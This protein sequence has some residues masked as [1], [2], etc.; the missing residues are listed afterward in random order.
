M[1]GA[2]A[3]PIGVVPP[4][5][6]APPGGLPTPGAPPCGMPGAPAVPIGDAP[7]TPGAPPG[8]LPTPGAP[9]CGMPGEP[10]APVGPAPPVLDPVPPGFLMAGLTAPDPKPG[11]APAPPGP[12]PV[13]PGPVAPAPLPAAAPPPWP[14]TVPGVGALGLPWLAPAGGPPAGVFDSAGNGVTGVML[15]STVVAILVSGDGAVMSV[16]VVSPRL[17]P[18]ISMAT[19]PTTLTASTQETP[20]F[21]RER[22]WLWLSSREPF[23]WN[24]LGLFIGLARVRPFFEVCY[25]FLSFPLRN[26]PSKNSAAC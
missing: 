3:V 17:Q 6:G 2:P 18:P 15:V 20:S 19:R 10:V 25:M 23:R 8:G 22:R 1:T 14:G 5:P 9:P 7:P 4:A 21:R 24:G 12:I 26:F 13:L 16:G 11:N